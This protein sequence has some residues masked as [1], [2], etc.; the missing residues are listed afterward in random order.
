MAISDEQ[1]EDFQRQ[2]AARDA[3]DINRAL[4]VVEKA[5]E[6]FKATCTAVKDLRDKLPPNTS[7]TQSNA[8]GNLE[9]LYAQ[10]TGF[11]AQ[12]GYTR[13][14]LRG[15]QTQYSEYAEAAPKTA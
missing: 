9:N 14:S 10:V 13:D 12:M 7:F 2:I 1:Y 6:D 11:D 4:E 3:A 5:I 15:L 8:R